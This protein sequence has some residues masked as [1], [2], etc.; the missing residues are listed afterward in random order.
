MALFS[1]AMV[2]SALSLAETSFM[3]ATVQ[4]VLEP[5]DDAEAASDDDGAQ[6]D[7]GHK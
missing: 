7:G 5:I 4:P 2:A 1:A 3:V 6:D